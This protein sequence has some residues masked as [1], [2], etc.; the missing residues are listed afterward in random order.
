MIFLA[1]P[2]RGVEIVAASPSHGT[3]ETQNSWSLP[4]IDSPPEPDLVGD[5]G[6]SAVI[7]PQTREVPEEFDWSDQLTRNAFIR[8]EQKALAKRI[9]PRDLDRYQA[10]KQSRNSIIFGDRLLRDYAEVQRLKRLSE[11]LAEVQQFLKPITI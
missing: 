3:R 5:G 6:D 11:K 9:N 8:L 10:M 4:P 7:G 2:P 1:E